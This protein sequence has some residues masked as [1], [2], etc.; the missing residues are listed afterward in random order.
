[1]ILPKL[2]RHHLRHGDDT[3]FYR[4]QARDAIRWIAE[5]GVPIGSQTH[6]LDLGAG[7]GVFG[8]ELIKDGC[9]VTFSDEQNFLQPNLRD[10]P[11]RQ[12]D[13]DQENLSAVGRYDLV[14]CSNVLEHLSKPERLLHSIQ[15]CL[16]PNGYFFL[17][18]TNWL[19]P[20]GGHEFSPYHYLGPKLGPKLADKITGKTRKH[21]PYENLFPTS[22]G[23]TKK[24][25]RQNKAVRVISVAPRYY[26][27]F[28]FL[29]HLP[30][31]REFLSWNCAILLQR[32]NV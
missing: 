4:M 28:A 9:Q 29:C 25:L 19:S 23:Q 32:A 31:I 16:N 12:F 26:T 1:M 6:A 11:F 30:F 22:I 10:Q 24:M 27:E 13:L 5:N 18:W 21:T 2:I 14:I 8:A 15:D 7:H 3:E 17:S 20:W